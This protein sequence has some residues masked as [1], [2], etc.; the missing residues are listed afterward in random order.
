MKT[1]ENGERQH[2]H[3]HMNWVT[4][5]HP[6]RCFHID[7]YFHNSER[8]TIPTTSEQQL[9]VLQDH[10]SVHNY[11]LAKK[12]V[13]WDQNVVTI[14]HETKSGLHSIYTAKPRKVDQWNHS[15]VYTICNVQSP[16]RRLDTFSESKTMWSSVMAMSPVQ[17]WTR[18]CAASYAWYYNPTA[19]SFQ[20]LYWQTSIESI[21]QSLIFYI[22]FCQQL[23]TSTEYFQQPFDSIAHQQPRTWHCMLSIG[24]NV[25]NGDTYQH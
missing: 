13:M 5:T 18:I 1:D 7:I 17:K 9:K 8:I 11:R 12:W 2:T 3:T 19:N 10:R 16:C 25:A 20:P 6:Q 24:V 22:D 23:S 4:F 14:V 21:Q 15:H